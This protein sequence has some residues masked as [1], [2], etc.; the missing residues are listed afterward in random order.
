[1]KAKHFDFTAHSPKVYFPM[2]QAWRQGSG[3]SRLT[4]DRTSRASTPMVND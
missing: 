4:F 1:M 2:H 3:C